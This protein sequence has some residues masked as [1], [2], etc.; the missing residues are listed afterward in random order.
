M[1]AARQQ[2]TE[3]GRTVRTGQPDW[4][5]SPS[6]T[7]AV[8]VAVVFA[9]VGLLLSRAD[10]VLLALPLIAAAEWAWDRRLD[11]TQS[12]TFTVGVAARPGDAE[13]RF[14][15]TLAAPDGVE[16]V[17]LRLSSFEGRPQ[18]IVVTAESLRELTGRLP[19]LH[20]GP[21]EVLRVDYRLV[22]ADGALSACRRGR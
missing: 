15:L 8:V 17:A 9:T 10:L 4:T 7:A 5:L 19:L 1:T 16:A 21:Q 20:S 13:L 18:E 2:P 3:P 12:S 22:A 11:R 6:L 14:A